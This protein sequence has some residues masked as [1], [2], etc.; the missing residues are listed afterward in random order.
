[1]S[2]MNI[3]VFRFLKGHYSQR[4]LQIFLI[5]NVLQDITRYRLFSYFRQPHQISS[6]NPSPFTDT[7]KRFYVAFLNFYRQPLSCN[8]TSSFFCFRY[9]RPGHVYASDTF[10]QCAFFER[11]MTGAPPVITD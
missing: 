11:V 8:K 6:P 1:M 4:N 2:P 9:G 10:T 7:K 3:L 5:K